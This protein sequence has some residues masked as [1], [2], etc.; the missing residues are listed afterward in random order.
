M[1]EKNLLKAIKL[2][3]RNIGEN[4]TINID[5]ILKKKCQIKKSNGTNHVQQLNMPNVSLS[6][7]YEWINETSKPKIDHSNKSSA[8]NVKVGEFNQAWVN[9]ES[10]Q[11]PHRLISNAYEWINETPKLIQTDIPKPSALNVKVKELV[12][13]MNGLMRF[14]NFKM[15]KLRIN[16]KSNND[17]I[18]YSQA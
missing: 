14:L 6:D 3:R 12:T 1:V 2:R 13:R 15:F 10:N 11:M 7:A 18:R 4:T 9:G 17:S 8:L 5:L 16:G